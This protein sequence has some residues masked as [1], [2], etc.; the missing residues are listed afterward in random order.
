MSDDYFDYEVEISDTPCPKCRHGYTHRRDC[1]ALD[2]D[3][4]YYHDCGEDCCCCA[5]PVPN[6]K[7][8]ECRGRGWHN[9]CPNCGWDLLEK[10]YIN[11]RDERKAAK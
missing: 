3:E 10:R 1:T 5:D 9:W 6:R 4:G 8:D 2:C 7:C 11:G